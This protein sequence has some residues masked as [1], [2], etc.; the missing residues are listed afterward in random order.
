MRISIIICYIL[1]IVEQTYAQISPTL[2][3]HFLTE[4]SITDFDVYQDKAILLTDDG[5]VLEMDLTTDEV[6]DISMAFEGHDLALMNDVHIL[7][8]QAYLFGGD[9]NHLLRY[10]DG[11][12]DIAI[13]P[14]LEFNQSHGIMGNNYKSP[15]DQFKIATD[16][17]WYAIRNDT[18]YNSRYH[19]LDTYYYSDNQ[20]LVKD[21]VRV[22]GAHPDSLNLYIEY[23]GGVAGTGLYKDSTDLSMVNDAHIVPDPAY[24]GIYLSYAYAFLG[25]DQAMYVND[26]NNCYAPYTTYLEGH[27]I[28]DI[29]YFDVTGF[30]NYPTIDGSPLLVATD[31]GLYIVDD[32]GHTM[33]DPNFRLIESTLNIFL[34][35]INYDNC[36]NRFLISGETG[37]YELILNETVEVSFND[38]E[39]NRPFCSNMEYNLGAP[40]SEHFDFQWMHN[41]SPIGELNQEIINVEQEGSYHISYE[42]CRFSGDLAA[43]NFFEVTMVNAKMSFDGVTEKCYDDFT[44]LYAARVDE[45]I[46]N[47]GEYSLTYQWYK[48]GIP[49]EGEIDDRLRGNLPTGKYYFIATNCNGYTKK[50]DEVNLQVRDSVPKPVIINESFCYGDTLRLANAEGFSVQWKDYWEVLSENEYYVLENNDY[51]NDVVF[52][53]EFG[54]T[55]TL[56]VDIPYNLDSK[57]MIDL[58]EDTVYICD[59][60][61]INYFLY[62]DY[63]ATHVEWSD[64]VEGIQRTLDEP[65]EYIITAY[66]E[67]SECSATI[68]TLHVQRGVHVD[69]QLPEDLTLA[70]RD[71]LFIELNPAYDYYWNIGPMAENNTKI[72]TSRSS[73]QIELQCQVSDGENCDTFQSMIITFEH[74]GVLTNTIPEHEI[75]LY[76][77]PIVNNLMIDAKRSIQYI[78]IYD[79][80]GNLVHE[81]YPDNSDLIELNL[82]H[83][84]SGLYLVHIQDENDHYLTK[85]MS[86]K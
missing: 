33:Y 46:D 64:G 11:A 47:Y 54:C 27:Q 24:R 28:N 61:K 55:A 7:R 50:S 3:E 12:V 14:G 79:L 13:I 22:C 41:N 30:Y 70:V 65:G 26:L 29:F 20:Y 42:N 69:F 63:Y 73:G 71:T 6:M 85:T 32:V 52:T 1:L 35:K 21:V 58:P 82:L 4:Y 74:D 15:A 8:P 51:L 2:G 40:I 84:S 62:V 68:D 23:F 37:V 72:V 60:E 36:G 16:N 81:H 56:N 45:N 17:G 43:M 53:D 66:N 59:N 83:L 75:T 19:N 57:V 76:P 10:I 18:I 34:Q 44:V 67:Y 80:T 31:Q 38:Y 9:V 5:R 25:T 77:N 78:S 86:K 49:L 48:D 39:D